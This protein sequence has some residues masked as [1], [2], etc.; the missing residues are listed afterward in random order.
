M[1]AELIHSTDMKLYSVFQNRTRAFQRFVIADI[2]SPALNLFVWRGV[3][4]E[5]GK[6]DEILDT[7]YVSWVGQC[8][9]DA[10]MCAAS[11]ALR[12]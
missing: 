4:T 10:H 3:V 2:W 9:N 8:M 12:Y 7:R 11:R 6:F 5:F 1:Q